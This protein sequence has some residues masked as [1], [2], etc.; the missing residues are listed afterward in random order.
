VLDELDEI[1]VRPVTVAAPPAE[2]P[3]RRLGKSL[4]LALPTALSSAGGQND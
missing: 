3:P 1:E 2:E 4:T